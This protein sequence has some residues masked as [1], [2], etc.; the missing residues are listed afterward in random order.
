MLGCGALRTVGL[1]A[2]LSAVSSSGSAA[3]ATTVL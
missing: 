2:V 3:W 1:E